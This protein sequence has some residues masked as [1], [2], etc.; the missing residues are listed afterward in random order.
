MVDGFFVHY[1]AP[2]AD[3]IDDLSARIVFVLDKSGSM[4]GRKF[5]QLQV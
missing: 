4:S 2:P 3:F 5:Q 1:F